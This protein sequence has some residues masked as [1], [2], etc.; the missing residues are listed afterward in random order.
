MNRYTVNF[1]CR[2]NEGHNV[3]RSEEFDWVGV[4]LEGVDKVIEMVRR[5]WREWDI[6]I[7]WAGVRHTDGGL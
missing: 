7:L 5:K 1:I 4:R 2:D 6:E 3:V